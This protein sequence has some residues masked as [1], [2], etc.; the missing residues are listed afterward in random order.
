[1]GSNKP[2]RANDMLEIFLG[3]E[4]GRFVNLFR[5]AS[6]DVIKVMISELEKV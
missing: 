3:R 6:E 4:F 5:S 1:M 2:L